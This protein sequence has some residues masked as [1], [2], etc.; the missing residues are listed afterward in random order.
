MYDQSCKDPRTELRARIRELAH[1]RVRFGYRRLHV[2]LRREGWD[3][4]K[5]QAHPNSC[6]SQSLSGSADAK[7][8][9]CCRAA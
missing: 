7:S 3:I 5:N 8:P 2:L 4:G 9:R 6:Q 1:T